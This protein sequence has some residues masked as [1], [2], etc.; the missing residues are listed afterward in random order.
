MRGTLL[1]TVRLVV[2]V[3]LGPT[4]AQT[5]I[6]AWALGQATVHH[7]S[8]TLRVALSLSGGISYG[9]YQAGLN[10]ALVD[11][12][13]RQDLGRL[14]FLPNHRTEQLPDKVSIAAAT[15]ASAG[16]VNALITALEWCRTDLPKPEE[17]LFWR[18][19]VNVGLTQLLPQVPYGLEGNASIAADG[20]QVVGDSAVFHRRFFHEVPYVHLTERM[21]DNNNLRSGDCSVPVGISLTRLNPGYLQLGA[22]GGDSLPIATQRYVTVFKAEK[23]SDRLTFTQPD[24]DFFSENPAIGK[25]LVLADDF[26]PDTSH[27]LDMSTVLAAVEAASA[28]PIAFPPVELNFFSDEAACRR[29]SLC[30]TQFL[31]GGLFDNNPLAL[32]LSILRYEEDVDRPEQRRIVYIDPGRA[33]ASA[34]VDV[35]EAE[36]SLG[37]AAAAQMIRGGIPAARQYELQSL[38]RFLSPADQAALSVTDRGYPVYGQ[39]LGSFG[40]FIGR[41]FREHDFFVGVFDG[42]Y[43]F[44]REFVC[45]RAPEGEYVKQDGRVACIEETVTALVEGHPGLSLAGAAVVDAVHTRQFGAVPT[46]DPARGTGDPVESARLRLQR[47]LLLADSAL[48]LVSEPRVCSDVDMFHKLAC[49]EGLEEAALRFPASALALADSIARLPACATEAISTRAIEPECIAEVAFVDFMRQPSGF[50]AELTL[51]VLRQL[52]RVQNAYDPSETSGIENVVEMAEIYYRS[53]IYPRYQRG[54]DN[55]V[56]TVPSSGKGTFVAQFLV[57]FEVSALSQANG[58]RL[59][60]MWRPLTW[61]LN[62]DWAGAPSFGGQYG[63]GAAEGFQYEVRG[64]LYKKSASAFLPVLEISALGVYDCG[65]VRLPWKCGVEAEWRPGVSVGVHIIG[66]KLRIAPRWIFGGSNSGIDPAQVSLGFSDVGG[67]VYWT[68]RLGVWNG[69]KFW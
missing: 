57:P 17:S 68:T 45:S 6:P 66:G 5:A 13:K 11:L 62:A 30:S 67:L 3:L 34:P 59:Q 63:F 21:A 24:A 41:P 38:A 51:K 47:G 65:P 36:A 54:T 69:L 49:K 22:P 29:L 10:Y 48:G 1:G 16:N 37:L 25:W 26:G 2:F 53:V 9:S 23:R 64:S 60:T 55:S 7:T 46:R 31:D 8:D 44:A 39:T 32:A 19:W 28:Y 50:L 42:F 27:E 56:G 52:W 33:R 58:F 61:H 43:F 35:L 18:T 12:L 40:A 20:T 14:D 15:G 4:L